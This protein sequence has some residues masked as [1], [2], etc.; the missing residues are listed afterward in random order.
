MEEERKDSI[1]NIISE[2][3]GDFGF[4]ELEKTKISESAS[5]EIE[6]K[7]ITKGVYK[8]PNNKS[9]IFCSFADKSLLKPEMQ[10]QLENQIEVDEIYHGEKYLL[11]KTKN[12]IYGYDIVDFIDLR[13]I[14]DELDYH[15]D[16]KTEDF[17]IGIGQK[18]LENILIIST[19][20]CD[21][22]LS[23]Y[24]LEN[25]EEEER[26]LLSQKLEKSQPFF[27]FKS[28][29][30]FEWENL[31]GDKDRQ[32]ERICELLLQRE[33][34]I[35][36][37]I[38]IG[39]TRAADRGRD[40]EI[41]EKTTQLNSVIEKKW[42]VQCKFSVN[43]ISPSVLSGWTDRMIEHKYDGFWL[44]TNNDITPSLFDQLKDVESNESYNIVTKV[45]Q[46]SDFFIKLNINSELF[47]NGDIF[48]IE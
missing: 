21:F 10:F 46:R 24:L 7:T 2:I 48:K 19:E 3:V 6:I 23:G 1:R 42:L 20:I 39:K 38:P 22:A 29:I 35:V 31:L 9:G 33:N 18:P 11:C 43:S 16:F 30:N 32:F 28:P 15:L 5:E 25:L 27:E 45:W 44:M 13:S 40:F 14:I 41:I 37:I 4:T 34:D 8:G 12:R 26:I 47:T 17:H 36:S